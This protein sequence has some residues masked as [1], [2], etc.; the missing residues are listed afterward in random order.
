[1]ANTGDLGIKK[2]D[3]YYSIRFPKELD[4]KVISGPKNDQGN[5]MVPNV[6]ES[7]AYD[8]NIKTVAGQ[9]GSNIHPG[10]RGRIFTL[11][12]TIPAPGDYVLPYYFSTE[13]GF[14]PRSVVVDGMNEP[15]RGLGKMV[16]RVTRT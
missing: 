7:V 14:V 4:L 11:R 12:V 9:I 3:I 15:V 5:M 2:D 16:L 6:H 13:Q 8:A 10:R 1:V